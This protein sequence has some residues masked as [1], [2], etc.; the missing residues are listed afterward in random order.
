MDQRVER[1]PGEPDPG[2]SNRFSW[3][4][5]YCNR[6]LKPLSKKKSTKKED[7]AEPI[8][9]T[10]FIKRLRGMPEG[11]DRDWFLYG[12]KY[13]KEPY[14]N[15]GLFSTAHGGNVSGT[16]LRC[17]DTNTNWI[18]KDADGKDVEYGKNF[19]MFLS[20]I[21][22]ELLADKVKRDA[23]GIATLTVERI[24]IEACTMERAGNIDASMD[25][26]YDHFDELLHKEGP[27]FL[28][29]FIKTFDGDSCTPHAL[30]AFMTVLGMSRH[31]LSNWKDF[32]QNLEGTLIVNDYPEI[33]RV[34]ER[35]NNI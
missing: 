21:R 12:F 5:W 16:L 24:L 35:F 19:N 34:V 13:S 27:V 10:E 29:P 1:L 11:V 7:N 17:L 20:L 2:F 18:E 26:I 30:M 3:W 32:I 23:I 28:N 8:T 9:A 6:F 14:K 15:V 4:M 33:T 25:H 31:Q 22:K